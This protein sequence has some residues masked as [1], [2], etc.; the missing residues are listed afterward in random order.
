MEKEWR[1]GGRS[2]ILIHSPVDL[3][4]QSYSKPKP[5]VRNVIQ[6]PLQVAWARGV[7][8]SFAI[9]PGTLAVIW[10]RSRAAR[11]RSDT[12][13]EYCHLRR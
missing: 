4:S 5:G 1:Q 7:D 3:T 10:V 11:T 2:T 6:I 8:P 13:M 9:F 12:H